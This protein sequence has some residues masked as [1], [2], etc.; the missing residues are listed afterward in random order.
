MLFPRRSEIIKVAPLQAASAGILGTSQPVKL[1]RTWPIEE[2]QVIL[3]GTIGTQLTFTASPTTNAAVDRLSGLLKQFQLFANDGTEPRTVVRASGIGLL[4]YAHQ[5]GLNLPAS[6]LATMVTEQ[7]ATAAASLSFRI[8]YRVP[9]VHPMFGEPL[10]TRCL[11]PAH[12]LPQDPTLQLDFANLADFTTLGSLTSLMCE[13]RCIYRAIPPAVDAQ[14]LASGGYI[15]SDLLQTDTPLNIG[16]SAEQDFDI[17]LAG[18]YTGLLL[19]TYKG[20]TTISRDVIDSSTTLGQ[21]SI[22]YL[23]QGTVTIE[24]FRMRDQ[25]DLND[26]SRVLNSATQSSSPA[27]GG[28]VAANTNFQPAASVYM[29]FVSDGLESVTELGSAL[30]ANVPANS[31]LKLQIHGTI[32]ASVTVAHTFSIIGHRLFG[33]IARFQANAA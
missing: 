33:D 22:W 31:G 26:Y 28:A 24:E 23:R 20:N 4:E 10:R 1:N 25:R 8:C 2:I 3:T 15:P 27:F 5:A 11:F 9:L 17:P 30:D 7:G 14:I 12:R 19:R 18:N 6:T 29:D 16:S 21:E 13:V 32:A